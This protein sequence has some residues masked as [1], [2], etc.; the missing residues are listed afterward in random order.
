MVRSMMFA[1][2]LGLLCAA[3]AQADVISLMHM[4][5][6][7]GSTTFTDEAGGTW[8]AVAG[9]TQLK[10]TPVKFGTASLRSAGYIENSDTT[11]LEL[12]ASTSFTID[13]WLYLNTLT[14]S[15]YVAGKSNP[16]YGKGYDIRVIDGGIAV[17]GV[18]GWGSG[19][20]S[21]SNIL[22]A[23]T[24]QHIALTADCSTVWM[25]VDGQLQA[26]TTRDINGAL[27][28]DRGFRIGTQT[29]YAGNGLD[30]YMDEF[31]FVSGQA[32]W[33]ASFIPPTSPYVIP[34]PGTLSLLGLG[35]LWLIRRRRRD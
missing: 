29:D 27:A 28:S 14:N 11:A 9:N 34:E 1:A 19:F 7:D 18:H 4:D 31:R 6:S 20:Y 25:F 22:Y 21:P 35:G 10:T 3:Q 2:L 32:A 16:D 24:W 8:S 17:F 30:G 26:T 33:T 15:Q 12:G 13:F 23:E 5:G